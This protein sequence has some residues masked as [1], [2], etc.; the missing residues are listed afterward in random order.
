MEGSSI[1]P[2]KNDCSSTKKPST[3]STKASRPGL[4]PERRRG[5]PTTGVG[6][7]PEPR[8]ACWKRRPDTLA[9]QE[10]CSRE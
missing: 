2:D 10:K 3:N 6:G 4:G 7:A 5:A 8:P 9:S 1:K